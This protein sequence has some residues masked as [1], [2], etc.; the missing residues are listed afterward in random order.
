[1]GF[2]KEKVGNQLVRPQDGYQGGI[3][4]KQ[5][6]WFSFCCSVLF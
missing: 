3:Y 1:M 2:Q 4:L 6:P 5:L